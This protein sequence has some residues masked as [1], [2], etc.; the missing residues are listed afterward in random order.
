M[1]AFQPNQLERLIEQY[2]HAWNVAS[3]KN[4]PAAAL[5]DSTIRRALRLTTVRSLPSVSFVAY[6]EI[7]TDLLI[8][9]VAIIRYQDVF[10]P[11][12]TEAAEPEMA[13]TGVSDE[14]ATLGVHRP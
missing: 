8:E 3:V 13:G 1:I 7:P 9:P 10:G 12:E 6:N 14:P 2:Q 4:E 11:R 5:V